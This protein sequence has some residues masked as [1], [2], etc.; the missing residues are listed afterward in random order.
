MTRRLSLAVA[1]FLGSPGINVLPGMVSER[2]VV[3]EGMELPVW[4]ECEAGSAVVVGVRPEALRLGGRLPA[5]VEHLEFLG[6]EVLLHARFAG[7]GLVA[8]LPVAATEGVRAG[9]EVGLAVDWGRALVF[10]ADGARL[11]LREAAYVDV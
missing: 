4:P 7:V 2:G 5:S 8:R 6:S 1:Q 11:R 9:D 10:G 3:V